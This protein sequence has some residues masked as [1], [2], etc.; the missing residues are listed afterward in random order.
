MSPKN[1]RVVVPLRQPGLWFVRVLHMVPAKD[2]P[3]AFPTSAPTPHP[4]AALD[5]FLAGAEQVAPVRQVDGRDMENPFFH[6]YLFL[7]RPYRFIFR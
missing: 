1:G 4:V 2:D 3:V 7:S 6:L 5:P